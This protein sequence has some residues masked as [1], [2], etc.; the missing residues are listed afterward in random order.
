MGSMESR[1]AALVNDFTPNLAEFEQRAAHHLAT[2][3]GCESAWFATF[4]P[5]FTDGLPDYFRKIIADP[6]RYDRDQQRSRE[7]VA[8]FGTTFID[9]E[10]YTADERDRL[11]IFRELMRPA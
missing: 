5:R 3:F 4:G 1:V 10:A 7:I 8:R 9:T 6:Q 2:Y 11:P